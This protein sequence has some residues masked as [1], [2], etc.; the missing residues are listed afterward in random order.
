LGIRRA[1]RPR[2][3]DDVF[4]QLAAAILRGTL[5]MG[6]R[7]PSEQELA[8]RFGLSRIIVRQ[9]LHRL[10]DVG[11]VRVRQGGATEVSDYRLAGDLSLFELEFRLGPATAADVRAFAE[12]ELSMAHSLLWAAQ[13]RGTAAEFA[14]LDEMVEAFVAGGAA[15]E[16]VAAFEERLWRRIARISRNRL[17]ELS[18][19]WWIRMRALQPRS[20]HPVRGTA[21]QRIDGYREMV[22]RL[23]SGEDAAER[24]LHDAATAL[25]FTDEK[26][27]GKRGGGKRRGTKHR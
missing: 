27:R 4:D 26:P 3:A 12:W 11:L 17:Y 9:A 16:D 19:N 8:E 1:P 7:L 5:S 6:D 15:A 20:M 10:A 18:C 2:A 13:R 21:E 22:R 24:F 25:G 23:F 14:E